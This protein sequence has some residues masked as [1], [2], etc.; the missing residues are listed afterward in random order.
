M[1]LLTTFYMLKNMERAAAKFYEVVYQKLAHLN[2]NMANFF[3]SLQEDEQRHEQKLEAA[4][5]L[6]KQSEDAFLEKKEGAQLLQ[7]MAE[8]IEE[9]SKKIQAPDY[10]VDIEEV[11]KVAAGFEFKMEGKHQSFFYEVKDEEIKSLLQEL[12]A[13]DQHHLQKIKAFLV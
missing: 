3:K 7:G 4:M 12:T 5:K 8:E 2:P 6:F 10:I 9:Q 11:I 13:A 1:A